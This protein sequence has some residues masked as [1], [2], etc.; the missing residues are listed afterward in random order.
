MI[1]LK[2]DS[3]IVIMAILTAVGCKKNEPQVDM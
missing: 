1:N 3:V 2:F